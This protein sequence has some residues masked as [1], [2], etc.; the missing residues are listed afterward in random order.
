VRFWPSRFLRS[1]LRR[2]APSL[3]L[4]APLLMIALAPGS[5]GEL[6]PLVA[7]LDLG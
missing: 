4:T 7:D 2:F 5:P 1:T 6:A 3:D